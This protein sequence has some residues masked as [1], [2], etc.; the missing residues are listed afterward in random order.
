LKQKTNEFEELMG[1]SKTL[2]EDI[3]KMWTELTEEE[4]KEMDEWELGWEHLD[5]FFSQIFVKK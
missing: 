2:Y 4:K 1:E 3:K 5:K